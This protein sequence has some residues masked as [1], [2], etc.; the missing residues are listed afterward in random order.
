MAGTVII[1]DNELFGS[2]QVDNRFIESYLADAP[3]GA[4]KVYLYALMLV[5]K[6]GGEGSDIASALKMDE[7]QI[8]EAFLYWEK[9]GLV[10]IAYGENG[11]LAVR[12]LSIPGSRGNEEDISSAIRTQRYSD[13][14]AKLQNVIGTRNLSGSE[15]S[16]I[17]DWIEVFRFEE[18]AAVEIVRHCLELK[19]ARVHINY[20]DAAA[21]R[22]AADGMLTKDAVVESFR[23][24][25][26]L[27]GGA[28][29]ILKRWNIT[30]RPTKD[31]IL[32]YE[33]WT[34]DW[35]FTEDA[36]NIALGD[37]VAVDRPNFK[38]FDAIL[39]SYHESGSVSSDKMKEFIREQDMI[40]EIARQAFTRAGLKRKANAND[41]RQFEFWVREY[42]M[43]AELILFAA[44]L[45]SKKGTPFAAM[46]QIITDW[47]ERGIASFS[48]AKEDSE[49]QEALRPRGFAQGKSTKNAF[50]Y[51]Q[52]NYTA[53][54]LKKLGIDTGEDV[55]NED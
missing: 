55:Y 23:K 46:K 38:Y 33:K 29:S 15:L 7:N 47:H 2:T 31:E 32:L 18:D 13:L 50:N 51:Q 48:A 20:M 6:A 43:D 17:Y 44:E 40:A 21:K 16:R 4:I 39:S 22:L 28:A 10:R 34:K 30:R 42:H 27:S 41:R 11:N 52:H 1:K 8:N 45:S 49:R 36:I 24:E 12:F 26:E 19:G 9:A 5:S 3:D 14:I 25:T 54:E 37:V 53:E 35:G